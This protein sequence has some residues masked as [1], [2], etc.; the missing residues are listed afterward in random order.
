[1]SWIMS[2]SSSLFHKYIEVGSIKCFTR[3]LPLSAGKVDPIYNRHS[4]TANLH[5][6]SR[7]FSSRLEEK[8]N[9]YNFFKKVRR[10]VKGERVVDCEST[11]NRWHD[12]FATVR[13]LLSWVQLQKVM[14]HHTRP[15]HII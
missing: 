15:P 10:R 12:N 14:L 5:N 4:S 2:S 13:F 1:M 8:G 7:L 11:N 3:L 9:I 6:L